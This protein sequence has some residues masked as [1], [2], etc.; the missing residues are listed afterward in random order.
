MLITT[1]EG[2]PR[3]PGSLAALL[4]RAGEQEPGG[5]AAS[6]TFEHLEDAEERGL[7][8]AIGARCVRIGSA[9]ERPEGHAVRLCAA[10]SLA[11]PRKVPRGASAGPLCASQAAREAYDRAENS[12]K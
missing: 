11:R 4:T 7:V 1:A 2:S 9:T 3:R 10:P 12:D 8:A 6:G 5:S